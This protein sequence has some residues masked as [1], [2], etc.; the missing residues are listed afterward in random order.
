MLTT[1]IVRDQLG[2]DHRLRELGL[3]R[4]GLETVAL[5]AA[6]AIRSSVTNDPVSAGGLLG[7]IFGTRA[8]REAFGPKDGW[9]IDR[10]NNVEAIQN[11]QTG[12]K[13]IYQNSESACQICP[14]RPRSHK[15]HGC[16][17]IV[18]RQTQLDLSGGGVSAPD[19]F[20]ENQ[21]VWFYCVTVIGD[22]IY[23]ELARPLSI[24]DGI[25]KDFAE[26]IFICSGDGGFVDVQDKPSGEDGDIEPVVV[27]SRK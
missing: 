21:N 11:D 24:D 8:M 3:D 12:I 19:G 23:A 14:P 1:R 2:V 15:G 17:E 25:F 18:N 9:K 7:W 5:R 20:L 27:V 13:L 6:T 22:K 16:A 10:T 26:R 4:A